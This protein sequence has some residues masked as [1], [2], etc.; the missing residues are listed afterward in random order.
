MEQNIWTAIII[1]IKSTGWA[2]MINVEKLNIVKTKNT[3]IL[4]LRMESKQ[5]YFITHGREQKK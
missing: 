1:I 2:G 3:S 5:F 4:I